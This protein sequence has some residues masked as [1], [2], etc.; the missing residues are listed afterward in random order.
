[1]PFHKSCLLIPLLF[2][3]VL[4]AGA[5]NEWLADFVERFVIA[6]PS[7]FNSQSFWTELYACLAAGQDL[8]AINC[9]MQHRY[10]GVTMLYCTARL[11]DIELVEALLKAGADQKIREY[12]NLNTP[13]HAASEQGH[14]DVVKLLCTYEAPVNMQN[15]QGQTALH[16]AALKG[17]V[18]LCKQLLSFGARSDIRDLYAKL[19]IQYA[20]A[21]EYADVVALLTA[22]RA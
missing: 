1:M 6:E 2:L 16:R 17:D 10:S 8:Q 7:E 11:G 14:L 12:I 22:H 18:A 5:T 20:Q 3:S 9:N 19:P 4:P 13:L 15:K 21:R